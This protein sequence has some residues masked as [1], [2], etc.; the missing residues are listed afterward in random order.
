[1]LS[2]D[3]SIDIPVFNQMGV[4]LGAQ[5]PPIEGLDIVDSIAEPVGT[6]VRIYQPQRNQSSLPLIVY[7]HGGGYISG[8]LE[9]ED[10]QCRILAAKVPAIVVSVDYPLAPANDFTSIIKASLRTV[11]WAQAQQLTTSRQLLLAGGSAGGSLVIQLTYHYAI[12]SDPHRLTGLVVLFPFCAPIDLYTGPHADEMKSMDEKAEG[13]PFLT[14]QVMIGM[15]DPL[16][17]D[18][19][20]PEHFALLAPPEV[21]AKFPRTYVV[22]AEHDP[23]RDDGR[24]LV[25]RLRN[26]CGKGVKEDYYEGVPHYFFWFPMLSLAHECMADIVKG[27]QWVLVA[28]KDA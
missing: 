7:F 9:S 27:V 23:V 24:I 22:T 20:S 6:R 28:D 1:M 19:T 5:W 26:E 10:P 25:K 4:Q 13:A 14:K 15:Y 12:S 11:D 18:L 21:L 16:K 17:P 2:G 8:D 3:Q